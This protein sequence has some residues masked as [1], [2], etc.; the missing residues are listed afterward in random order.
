MV[1]I[2]SAAARTISG[3]IER[4]VWM[5][6]A[7]LNWRYASARSASAFASASPLVK[8]MPASALP[9]SFVFSASAWALTRTTRAF[10]SPFVI[11]IG[12][13][14]LSRRA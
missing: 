9:S 2:G 6:A 4:T 13:L 11:V 5:I 12:G 1:A 10:A 3:S 8:V 14:G 7:S